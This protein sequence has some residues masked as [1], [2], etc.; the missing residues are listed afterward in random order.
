MLIIL[1]SAAS[2]H[3]AGE[4]HAEIEGAKESGPQALVAEDA[5]GGDVE[6]GDAMAEAGADQSE[7]PG[8]NSGF[9]PMNN[10][11]NMN[12]GNGDMTQMQMMMAMQN[13]MNP[14]AFGSFP[15]MGSFLLTM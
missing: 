4:Q 2:G 1:Q 15:M 11:F 13:G 12:F 8:M 6:E 10:N 5:T 9:D 3:P 7:Q 14:A